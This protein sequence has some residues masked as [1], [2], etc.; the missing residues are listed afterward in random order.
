M[1]RKKLLYFVVP[2]LVCGVTAFAASEQQSDAT[3]QLAAKLYTSQDGAVNDFLAAIRQFGEMS[4]I[5]TSARFLDNAIKAAGR[6]VSRNLDASRDMITQIQ[7]GLDQFDE[8]VRREVEMAE[9]LR[10][11]LDGVMQSFE[12]RI[13]AVEDA[14]GIKRGIFS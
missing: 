3:Q 9:Q 11:T 2:L 7:Q 4:E 1:Y 13:R 5:N 10:A 12:A 14:R 6:N 8:M